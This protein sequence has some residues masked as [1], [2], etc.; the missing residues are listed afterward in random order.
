MA[1]EDAIAIVTYVCIGLTCASV[2]LRTV[3]R[4]KWLD[5]GLRAEDW[6]MIVAWVSSM[7]IESRT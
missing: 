2:S 6:L 1:P 4:Y 3:V 7:S 5:V